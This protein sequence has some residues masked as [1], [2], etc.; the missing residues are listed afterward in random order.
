MLARC[1][2]GR[3]MVKVNQNGRNGLR[4]IDISQHCLSRI[5]SKEGQTG[6]FST[7]AF[8]ATRLHISSHH[9]EPIIMHAEQP[10]PKTVIEIT[11]L[12]A[13]NRHPLPFSP[14]LNPCPPSQLSLAPNQAPNQPRT[15]KAHRTSSSNLENRNSHNSS[16]THSTPRHLPNKQASQHLHLSSP[17]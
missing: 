7:E 5:A 4:E 13:H 8:H 6:H 12:L 11:L 3:C 14:T 17:L 1:T 2:M 16:H 9:H 10:S 15:P